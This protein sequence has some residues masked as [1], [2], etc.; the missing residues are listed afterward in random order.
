MSLFADSLIEEA[1]SSSLRKEADPSAGTNIASRI[2]KKHETLYLD[3]V[4]ANREISAAGIIT[5]LKYAYFEEPVTSNAPV[6]GHTLD[7]IEKTGILTTLPLRA[8][9]HC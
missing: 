3:K 9:V 7:W 5:L 2:E 4:F 6:N 1:K 8:T